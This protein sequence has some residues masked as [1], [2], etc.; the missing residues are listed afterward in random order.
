[1]LSDF[2]R[3]NMPF[4]EFDEEKLTNHFKISRD[5]RSVLYRPDNWPSQPKRLTSFTF[6]NVSF[7]KTAFKDMT[8]TN[9]H[10]EDSLFI[11]SKFLNVEFHRCKFVNCNFYKTEF[12]NCYIDPHTISFD[13]VYR[14]QMANIGVHLYHQLYQDASKSR[15]SSFEVKADIEF[16]RW[17]RWQLRY[18]Q[19]SGKITAFGGLREYFFSVIYELV[20]GFGYNPWRFVV[21]TVVLF[22]AF[23]LFNINILP[24]ALKQDG[25]IIQQMTV[26]DAIFYTYS[27]LTALGFSTIVPDTGFAKIL[28]VSE[29]LIGI[30]WLGVFTSLLV[31]KFI[32]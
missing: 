14:R 30:G 24:G 23:S 29:A 11:G 17:K 7:S 19:K 3:L 20:A 18:D 16:R 32:K 26:P 15:Q 2:F 4:E 10:F 13:K 25:Q 22:T 8:F 6:H 12:E 21:A 31:K 1:M 27:M 28:A 5:L 9:C